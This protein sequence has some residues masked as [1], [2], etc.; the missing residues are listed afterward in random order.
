MPSA[1][2]AIHLALGIESSPGFCVRSFDPAE[3][4]LDPAAVV[5]DADILAYDVGRHVL[6]LAYPRADLVSRIEPIPA[7]GVPF[8]LN[9]DGA[10]V[11]G[12][13]FWSTVSSQICC[14][15]VIIV[16]EFYREDVG[17]S[18][19]ALEYVDQLKVT[20]PPPDH[21]EDARLLDHFRTSGRLLGS[22]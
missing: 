20:P 6:Q 13:W 11:F 21:R 12:G 22:P 10:P 19:I 15:C 3:V 5:T 9:L 1:G 16:S 17:E 14:Q 8:V 4:A 7:S 18:E 2:A